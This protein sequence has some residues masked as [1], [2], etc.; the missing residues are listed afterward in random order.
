M[1]QGKKFR[2]QRLAPQAKI[3]KIKF[4]WKIFRIKRFENLYDIGIIGI[5][6]HPKHPRGSCCIRN[7]VSKMRATIQG[8][9]YDEVTKLIPQ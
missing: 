8:A 3:H 5:L 4:P 2:L 7:H 6:Y 9:N 1:I